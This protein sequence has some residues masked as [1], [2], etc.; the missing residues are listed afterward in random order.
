[1]TGRDNTLHPHVRNASRRLQP[2][3]RFQASGF[4]AAAAAWGPLVCAEIGWRAIY[5]G[6]SLPH[7]IAVAAGATHMSFSALL[8][9]VGV[10]IGLLVRQRREQAAT[11][12]GQAAAQAVIGERLR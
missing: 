8:V 1:M 7:R 3:H 5:G 11:M 6:G 12:R 9:A 2:V 10:M 4:G